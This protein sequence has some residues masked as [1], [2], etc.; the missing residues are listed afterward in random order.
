MKRLQIHGI[1]C[2][3]LVA[4]ALTAWELGKPSAAVGLEQQRKALTPQEK[5]GRDIWFKS[6]FGGERFF[7]SNSRSQDK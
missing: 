6:T 3:L 7:S 4:V 2:A 1:T 5:R